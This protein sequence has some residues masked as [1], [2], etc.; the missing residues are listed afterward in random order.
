MAQ[1]YDVQVY[2]MICYPGQEPRTLINKLNIKNRIK[3]EQA[4]TNLLNLR[5]SEDL[6]KQVQKMD[7]ASLKALHNY[8]FQDVYDWAGEIRTYTTARNAI[9]FA[10]P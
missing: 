1:R 3:L 8:L 5:L 9:P 10:K 2:D 4:E 6:P 7:F